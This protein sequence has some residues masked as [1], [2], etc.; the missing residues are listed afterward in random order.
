MNL[1]KL[2]DLKEALGLLSGTAAARTKKSI[3]PQLM[4]LFVGITRP[5]S[6]LCLAVVADHMTEPQKTALIGNG[7]LVQDLRELR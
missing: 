4:N 3:P 7:W 6:L 5:K 2:Y 1:R